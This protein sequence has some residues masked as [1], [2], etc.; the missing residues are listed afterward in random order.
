MIVVGFFSVFFFAFSSWVHVAFLPQT[1]SPPHIP[2][3]S[4]ESR[5]WN[6]D[7]QREE[8]EAAVGTDEAAAW[9]TQGQVSLPRGQTGRVRPR[10][11]R[12]EWPRDGPEESDCWGGGCGAEGKCI[13]KYKKS[14]KIIQFRLTTSKN[15]IIAYFFFF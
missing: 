14:Q 6:A 1:C 3:P 2:A 10:R 12:R 15:S 9:D 11:P 5:G 8:A 13:K 4:G 7:W